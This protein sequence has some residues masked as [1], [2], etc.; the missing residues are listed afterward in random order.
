[1]GSV[2]NIK[3]IL[4]VTPDGKL[5]KLTTMRGSKKA[6]SFLFDKFLF[7]YSNNGNYET[8]VI[9]ADNPE[10]GDE[11]AQ[12]LIKSGRNVSVRRLSVGPVIGTHCGPRTIGLIFVN[13]MH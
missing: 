9:D 6:I 13:K 7:E 4:T 5:E 2:L 8:F 11:L 10:G 12:K 1:M 3:P